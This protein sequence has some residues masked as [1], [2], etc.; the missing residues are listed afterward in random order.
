MS[1]RI[2]IVEDEGIIARDIQRQLLDLGYDPVDIA[3]DGDD[4]VA[5]AGRLR[6]HLALMDI[7]L[8]GETDGIEAAITM[9]QRYD[10]P[11]VF[12]TAYAT[13]EVV[14]R[15]KRANP[16]G[17]IIK[18]FDAQILRTT[19]EIA[20]NKDRVDRELRT[21]EAGLAE[22]QRIAHVGSW[23]LDLTSGLLSWSSEACRIFELDPG[24][25][26]GPFE[27]F[28]NL[29]HPEDRAAVDAAYRGSLKHHTPYDVEHR[30]QMPDGRVKYVRE[31]GQTYYG[32][33]GRPTRSVGTVQDVTD[34]HR[35]D[36]LLRL[37][38]AAL[39]SVTSGVVITD[40][41]GTI[42]WVNPAFTAIS[43]YTLDEAVGRNPRE[44]LKSG[45][46]PRELY[47]E[48]WATILAGKVWH[49]ELTN[50]R[51]D[52][53]TQIEEQT[54]TPV[55]DA[56]GAIT[57]FVGVKRD[58]TQQK[59]LEQQF[60][61]AQKMEVVGRLA[62]GVAH[63]F[64]NLL[65]V[66]NGTCDL[67]LSE[68]PPETAIREELE[69]IQSA[70]D[71]A[72][73]LTKQLLAFSRKQVLSPAVVGVGALISQSAKM[74]RR[75]I[76]ED[77][78]LVLAIDGRADDNVFVDAGQLEQVVLN[79]AV[80][81]RDA[82]PSGG[83]LTIET[84]VVVAADASSERRLGLMKGDAVMLAVT[85][86][87]TGMTPEVRDRIFEPFFTTKEKGKGTGLGLATVYGIVHQSGGV[88]EVESEVGEGTTFRVYLPRVATAAVEPGA[89]GPRIT[90]GR[91]TVLLVEDE[92]QLRRTT[93]KM[94]ANAGYEVVPATSAEEAIALLRLTPNVALVISDVVMPG[95]SGAE[96]AE[97]LAQTHPKL[98]VL[99]ISGYTDDKLTKLDAY[100]PAFFLAKPYT[101]AEL[102]KKVRQLLDTPMR[103]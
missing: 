70:A 15:A 48:L 64:N 27:I 11:C 88:I 51:K 26:K 36:E 100:D 30:L 93:T 42:Q 28:L 74:L 4:A 12:L 5:I 59:R 31:R 95:M 23:E 102:T 20:L 62:G 52:G 77:I 49:G 65:T 92:E 37:Q 69:D 101:L 16:S 14:E 82:M 46:H 81:A 78:A 40:T 75:L 83:R 25:T 44:I 56:S 96:L 85:D 60:L 24:L 55:R 86:T 10:I 43:G 58:L 72:T 22:A 80:N 47:E 90:R 63:D 66:I 9:R 18:P 38:S 17:Y 45:V 99:L 7:N 97:H 67:L 32:D 50:R 35:S 57:H 53:S 34:R 79:L 87:G 6:P 89:Q 1:T 94:L 68:L 103:A 2:L 61:Q 71:R 84:K 73:R 54:I 98:P 41:D 29:V 39:N 13:D 33:D 76:G 8:A 19:I 21:S 91:E 3:V